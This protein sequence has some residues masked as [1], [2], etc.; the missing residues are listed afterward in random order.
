MTS[1]R[2]ARLIM[3]LRYVLPVGWIAGAIVATSFLP[4]IQEAQTGA[5]GD[6]V[7][8]DAAAIDAEQRAAELFGFPLLTRTI[9]VQRDP[10][11]L[12]AAEQAR[13]FARA[14]RITTGREPSLIGIAAALPVT[15]AVGAAPFARERSTTALTY[16]IFDPAR[17]RQ[18]RETYTERLRSSIERR[19]DHPVGVTGAVPARTAQAQ[20]VQDSLPLVELATLLLV[21]LVVGLHFRALLA[22]VM[23]LAAIAIAYLIAMRAIA[24]IGQTAGVSVPSEVEPVVVVLLFGIVTD[25]AIFFLSRFRQRLADGQPAARAA[26]SATAELQGIVFTAGLIVAAGS[27]SLVVAK[28]GFFQAFGPGMALA[29]AVGLAVALTFIPSCLALFGS[30]L[31]W[32]SRPG[33]EISPGQAAEEGPDPPHGRRRRRARAVS[34]AAQRPVTVVC[35]TTLALLAAASGLV[36]LELGQTLIRGLPHDS[37]ARLAYLSAA[38]GFAPGILSP[39]M[40]LVEGRGIAGRR[41]SLLELQ[42]RIAGRQ[43]VAQVVGPAQQPTE[44]YLGAVFS[45]DG[46]AV[47]FLVVFDRDPL[48]ASAIRHLTLL[49]RDLPQLLAASGLPDARASIAGDTAL[50]AETVG[51]A[52]GDVARV[53]PTVL[54]V[55]FVILAV[56]LRSLVAPLYLVA[57]SVLALGAALGATVYVFDGLFGY[58]EMTYFVPFAAA[59]LL[60]PLGS[61]YNVFLTGRIWQEARTRPLREA[62]AVAGGRAQT[63][64]T[65]AGLV[66]ALSFAMLAIV[67]LRPFRELAFAMSAGLLIDAFVVRTMLVP[68]LISLVGER[69]AWPS[70]LRARA[71]GEAAAPADGAV[72]RPSG[73]GVAQLQPPLRDAK[74]GEGRPVRAR[75]SRRQLLAGSASVLTVLAAA[76]AA[77]AAVERRRR[78]RRRRGL[79]ARLG[80]AVRRRPRLPPTRRR[81]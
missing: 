60:V 81:G 40:L 43:A 16:L 63:A 76:A 12:S 37:E 7:P 62:I 49:R 20:A 27:A 18:A 10:N 15:N 4:T 46:D 33:R 57:T 50:A 52:R 41:E 29:V 77:A 72:S 19:E 39:T 21:V 31:L 5:L 45:R 78:R 74:A 68:A 64:I 36:K 69:S 9:V 58:D 26:E 1:S 67:P 55:V 34:F 54:L 42:R 17:N 14:V 80:H 8:N 30:A 6:L 53:A 24:G 35:V 13:V 75:P 79:R 3:R 73:V 48:G 11:G 56:F 47:R 66:L 71:R 22:P 59:V 25:Y 61:D 44:R 51:D 32:P 28:L 70:R 65:I 2:F 23:T 38:R